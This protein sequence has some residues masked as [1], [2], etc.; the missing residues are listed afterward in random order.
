MSIPGESRVVCEFKEAVATSLR[1]GKIPES[2]DTS[3]ANAGKKPV[4][5]ASAL[6]PRHKP[7]RFVAQTLPSE[8]VKNLSE[9]FR[10]VPDRR[11]SA[12]TNDTRVGGHEAE[13]TST[14]TESDSENQPA[15]AAATTADTRAVSLN[16]LFGED[17]FT[18]DPDHNEVELYFNEPCI[19]PQENPLQVEEK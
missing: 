15:G 11:T 1:K 10:R 7:L 3:A 14:A 9:M 2:D 6:D 18:E 8:I 4:Y 19:P 17:Y 5:I 12:A 16:T 13:G